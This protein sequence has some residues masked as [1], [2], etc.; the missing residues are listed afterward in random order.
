M[1]QSHSQA[2]FKRPGRDDFLKGKEEPILNPV[3]AWTL[4]IFIGPI[5]GI[6]VWVD[7]NIRKTLQ[8]P[9]IQKKKEEYQREKKRQD[10]W[11]EKTKSNS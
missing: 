5:L 7:W 3:F 1:C 4:A 8:D 9:E 11:K 10:E 6:W 2:R